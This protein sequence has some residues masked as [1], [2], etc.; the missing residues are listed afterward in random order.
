M[1]QYIHGGRGEQGLY[2][3][4]SSSRTPDFYDKGRVIY[5]SSGKAGGRRYPTGLCR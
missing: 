3:S 4:Q 1:R 2:T 5:D